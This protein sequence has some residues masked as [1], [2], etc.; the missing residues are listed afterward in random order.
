MAIGYADPTA[1]INRMWADRAPLDEFCQFIGSEYSGRVKPSSFW[2][3]LLQRLFS[4]NRWKIFFTS[5]SI[6]LPSAIPNTTPNDPIARLEKKLE[7][8]RGQARL[9]A[10][11]MGL[12]AIDS[13]TVRDQY[14][15]A[16][17]GF[18]ER[19]HP[20]GANRARALRERF[21]SATMFPSATCNAAR[22]W[23]SP[24]SIPRKAS[25]STRSTPAKTAQPSILAP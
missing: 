7:S 11:R 4:R 15:F 6:T 5:R 22:C 1:T 14:R 3:V 13:E 16:G 20:G 9:R 17:S 24:A 12:F 18:L 21:I 10:E 19:Q 23:S 25:I 2:R 8:G